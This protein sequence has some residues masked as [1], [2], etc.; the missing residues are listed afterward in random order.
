MLVL[1]R[2]SG[3]GVEMN[4]VVGDSY[5]YIHREINPKQFRETF[6]VVF[7]KDHVADNDESADKNTKDCYAFVCCGYIQPLYKNQKNFMMTE[8][9]N[10]FANLTYK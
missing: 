8:N 1:R 10:T 3:D 7:D 6:K 9:G 2:I 5:T 4:H